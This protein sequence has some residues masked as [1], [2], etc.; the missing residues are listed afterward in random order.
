MVERST[1]S[2]ALGTKW[3]FV[4]GETSELVR[5]A[6]YQGRG[7]SPRT[8]VLRYNFET[9]MWGANANNVKG[10]EAEPAGIMYKNVERVE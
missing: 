4:G 9:G 3:V 1:S 6:W 5:Y 8:Y 10:Q 2:D 7:R